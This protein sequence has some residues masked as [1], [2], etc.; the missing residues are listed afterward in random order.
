[1]AHPDGSAS[2]AS[3][4]GMN[5]E[6]TALPHTTVTLPSSKCLASPFHVGTVNVNKADLYAYLIPSKLELFPQTKSVIPSSLGLFKPS[7]L[8]FLA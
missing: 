1:M 6:T 3:C 2:D 5:I 4:P 7:P 8:C